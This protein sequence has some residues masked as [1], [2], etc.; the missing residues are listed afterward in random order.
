M[1]SIVVN[2][3]IKRVKYWFLILF[4]CVHKI[5]KSDH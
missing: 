2:M 3:I 4:R 5:V 1:C